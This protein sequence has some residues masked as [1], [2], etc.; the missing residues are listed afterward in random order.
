MDTWDY[1]SSSSSA[2]YQVTHADNG[3]LV[4]TCRGWTFKRGDKPR[5]CKHIDDVIKQQHLTVEVRGDY[6]FAFAA[7]APPGLTSGDDGSIIVTGQGDMDTMTTQVASAETVFAGMKASAMVEGKFGHLLDKSGK[8][9]GE[10]FDK[11]FKNGDWVMDEKLDGHRCQIMKR[12]DNITTTLRSIPSLPEH[13]IEDMRRLPFDIHLDGEL[14][15]PGG[16]STD[17]PNIEFR[18]Q[19]TF[20]AFDI[21]DVCGES[22]LHL[23]LTE[24]RGLLEAAAVHFQGGVQVVAQVDPSWEAVKAIWE[25]GG[26]GAILKQKA[27]PY[28]P[29]YR[30]AEWLKVKRLKQITVVVTG[31]ET[32]LQGPTGVVL[33]DLPNGTK[34][35]CKNKN[36][37]ELAETAANPQAYIGRRLVI[38]CQQLTRGGSPRH[39]MFDHWSCDDE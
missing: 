20:L 35:R 21:I 32:G 37:Q 31:F 1:P 30:G 3:V 24:R 17:V 27:S 7:D 26:E 36:N 2:M 16:I 14:V 8:I 13:I 18:S 12:G 19:L 29:A 10:L 4:C 9:I 15:V 28:R 5:R 33:F 23:P 22:S 6:V 11:A 38:Q 34:G 25:N 39:P